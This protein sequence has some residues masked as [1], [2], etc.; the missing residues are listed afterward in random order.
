MGH[1]Q[2]IIEVSVNLAHNCGVRI[3]RIP[4]LEP[5]KLIHV[6]IKEEGGGI[7]GWLRQHNW[8]MAA[9][10]GGF[11]EGVRNSYVSRSFPAHS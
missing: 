2:Q 7:A 6:M 5:L 1:R 10:E 11:D 4:Y 9:Q 8:Q 3:P